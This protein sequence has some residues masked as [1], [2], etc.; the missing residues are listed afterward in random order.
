MPWNKNNEGGGLREHEKFWAFIVLI[1]A[2][3]FMSWM[4]SSAEAET[5][6]NRGNL[7]RDAVI[8]LIG[9]AGMAAQALFRISTI[10]VKNA[11]TAQ[12]V[13]LNASSS[14]TPANPT[15]TIVENKPTDP[16]PTKPA[17]AAATEEQAPWDRPSASN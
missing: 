16:V 13:A 11:E 14:G 5:A 9:I 15:H 10:D 6:T 8:G 1:A 2:I 3:V 4:G 17:T 7:L 12:Q